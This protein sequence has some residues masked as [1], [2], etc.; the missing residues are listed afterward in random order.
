VAYDRKGKEI[1]SFSGRT[2]HIVNFI[3][4]VRSGRREDLNAEIED[5]HISTATGHTANIS[6]RVGKVASVKQ[7]RAEVDDVPGFHQSHDR[8]LVALKGHGIDPNTA[9]LGPWLEIDRE[10]ECI[11]DND[12]ANEI[13]RG[14]YREPYVVPEVTL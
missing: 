6:C 11:K 12:H 3:Q 10:K 5:G 9:M 2:D 8:F 4:A 1:K 13:V 7:Q 14:Y